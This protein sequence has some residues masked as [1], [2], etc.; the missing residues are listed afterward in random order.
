MV[1][2]TATSQ[3]TAKVRALA[4]AAKRANRTTSPDKHFE[5]SHQVYSTP[6]LAASGIFRWGKTPHE[7]SVVQMKAFS[8]YRGSRTSATI[9]RCSAVTILGCRPSREHQPVS[10]FLTSVRSNSGPVFLSRTHPLESF[11]E[12]ILL[13]AFWKPPLLKSSF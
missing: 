1:T 7:H 13:S 9:L 12:R 4:R 5:I 2:H 8:A 3:A 6:S 11:N 10:P